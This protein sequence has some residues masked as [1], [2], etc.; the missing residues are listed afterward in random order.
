MKIVGII[1]ATL[2]GLMLLAAI[3]WGWR[4]VTAPVRGIVGA[5]EQIESAASRITNYEH[6]FDLCAS[7]QG[8]EAAIRAAEAQ[9]DT[10]Q[11]GDASRSEVERVIAVLA[12][13]RA[14]RERAIARYNADASKSYTRARFLASDLPYRLDA[15]GE[16]LCTAQR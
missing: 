7:V 5:E 12:G 8:H 9:L 4:Y 15:R 10:L 14:Q 13:T 3:G 2:A 1:F 6:F 11:T 16:T